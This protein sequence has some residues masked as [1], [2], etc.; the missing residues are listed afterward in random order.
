MYNFSKHPDPD[1]LVILKDEVCWNVGSLWNLGVTV[2][3]GDR[4]WSNKEGFLTCILNS[5]FL[6]R[7][8]RKVGMVMFAG[9]VL[10]NVAACLRVGLKRKEKNDTLYFFNI[11][12]L[13]TWFFNLIN[14]HS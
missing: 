12:A 3:S 13:S 4:A 14:V 1:I 8:Q 5:F 11:A 9:N 6:V 7:N 2:Y 10:G